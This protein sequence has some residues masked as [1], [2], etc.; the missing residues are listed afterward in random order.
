[1]LRKRFFLYFS[2][3]LVF[4]FAYSQDTISIPKIYVCGEYVSAMPFQTDSTD[5]NGKKAD[6]FTLM[7][8]GIPSF[9]TVPISDNKTLKADKSHVFTLGKAISAT[10]VY[11]LQFP[12]L[13]NSFAE[14][15]MN[16]QSAGCF[17]VFLDREEKLTQKET[18]VSLEKASPKTQKLSLIPGFYM[19]NI[20]YFSVADQ[21]PRFKCFFSTTSSPSAVSF[22]EQTASGKRPINMTD[23]LSG[24]R[25]VRAGISPSGKYIAVTYS[26]TTP[27]GNKTYSHEIRTRTDRQLL[28][29]QT[30]N[31]FPG[32]LPNSDKIYYTKKEDNNRQLYISDPVTHSETLV[33]ENL[34]EGRI[35]WAPKED[36]IILAKEVKAEVSKGDFKQLTHPDDRIA[37][38]N[39]RTQLYKYDLATG[40]VQ[41]LTFGSR[42]CD[43]EDFS[44]DG[45]KILFSCTTKRLTKQPFYLHSLFEMDMKTFAVDT[46]WLE[47]EWIKGVSYSPDGKELLVTGSPDAFDGIGK[48]I[49][50]QPQA[51]YYDTQA[52]LYNLKNR[53]A[54]AISKDF[55]PN[56]HNARWDKND[57]K[58]YLLCEDRDYERLFSYDISK[59]AYTMLS[60]SLDVISSTDFATDAPYLVYISQGVS[61]Y[62]QVYWHDLLVDRS[63]LFSHPQKEVQDNLAFGEVKDRNFTS[64]DGTPI[65][66]RYYLPYNFDE[67]KQYPLIVYYYGGTSPVERTFGSNWNFH[68]W[69]S[70]GFVVYVIQPSGTTGFGQEF[71]ARHV[72]AWG[73]YTA[74]DIISA[75]QDFCESHNFINKNK[76]GCIGAS[77]GGFMTQYL[78][79][80]TDIFAAAVSHAG[81]SHITG[82][83]G[84]GYWGYGYNS[85]AAANSYPWNNPE[86]YGEQSPLT[87]ADKINTPLLLLHGMEDTN[88]PIG[89]SIQMYIALK[90]LGKDVAFVQVKGENHVIADYKHKIT[91]THTI[92]AWFAKYLQDDPAWWR[93]MY[94]D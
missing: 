7:S 44:G 54:K 69:A 37:G 32:W 10:K 15:T 85:I 77:Y 48:N 9:P 79:T 26:H 34:P 31:I 64:Q 30:G 63:T 80:C 87:H 41:P 17:R 1:M 49:G 29:K 4:G 90:L 28:Y 72:N 42:E 51:N 46:I 47:Q 88:V 18:H 6:F 73:K 25:P 38:N 55:M 86:L 94:K 35:Y 84:E 8:E 81:I 83:W 70:Q 5:M 58:I 60:T 2:L 23:V 12:I 16:I 21:T 52:F 24:I 56:I 20:Q 82:Y 59:G 14:I 92:M 78:Q 27:E 74:D 36:Y 76:V 57:N 68:Y 65:I 39:D 13:I 62:P 75:T 22:N 33:L 3:T 19:I 61:D 91:W 93:S 53:V 67:T 89:E 66:G 45:S 43:F 50:S 40:F 11:L 71:S